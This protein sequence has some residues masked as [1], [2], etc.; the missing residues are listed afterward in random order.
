MEGLVMQ[1]SP[2]S[3]YCLIHIANL[4]SIAVF[5]VDYGFLVNW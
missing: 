1:F 2:V 5:S 4:G 3:V